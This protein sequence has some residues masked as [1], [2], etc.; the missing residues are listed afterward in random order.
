MTKKTKITPPSAAYVTPAAFAVT[1]EHEQ[2][3]MNASGS[4]TLKDMGENDVYD[5]D[6]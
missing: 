4:A 2:C 3:I 6:F 1:L 5:E